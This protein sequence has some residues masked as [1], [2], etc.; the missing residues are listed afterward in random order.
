MDEKNPSKIV[1]LKRATEHIEEM[2][3]KEHEYL[4]KAYQLE[5][6]KYNLTN[7]IRKMKGQEPLNTPQ[8]QPPV[9][10]EK[11]VTRISTQLELDEE[12]E[13][14]EEIVTKRKTKTKPGS[15]RRKSKMMDDY[16]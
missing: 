2:Q 13:D 9:I 10:P 14:T 8:P 1:V 12:E 4:L 3:I 16:D 6:E 5:F 7:E 11:I 15:N